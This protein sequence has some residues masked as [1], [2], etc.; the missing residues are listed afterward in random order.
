LQI[1][2]LREQ[3][4]E[5]EMRSGRHG[6]LIGCHNVSEF[7]WVT[8]FLFFSPLIRGIPSIAEL[9]RQTNRLRVS[10]WFAQ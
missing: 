6:D 4:S 3:W 5:A 1:R 9:S 8:S 10:V 2:V 7:Q